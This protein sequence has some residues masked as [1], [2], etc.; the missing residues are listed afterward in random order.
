MECKHIKIE[1]SVWLISTA[2]RIWE[3]NGIALFSMQAVQNLGLTVTIIV[4]GVIVEQLGYFFLEL[5]FQAL[6][7]VALIAGAY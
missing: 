2:S 5:I 3:S 1:Y 4:A 7:C 6:L